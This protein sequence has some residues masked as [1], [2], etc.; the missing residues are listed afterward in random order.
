MS[1][2]KPARA[3]GETVPVPGR[4]RRSARKMKLFGPC[5][6]HGRVQG[7]CFKQRHTRPVPR[8]GRT[9]SAPPP[10]CRRFPAGE[11]SLKHAHPRQP[12]A[13]RHHPSRLP[14]PW[15][16]LSSLSR[17]SC[18]CLIACSCS[19]SRQ[20]PRPPRD[21]TCPALRPSRLFRRQLL[22]R[23]APAPSP[24]QAKPFP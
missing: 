19:A 2:P 17:A 3:R 9:P 10:G 12:S 5:S 8:T 15:R 14:L 4:I 16:P 20:K 11:S 23:P 1:R 7:G 6:S 22:L 24:R 21:S 18:P 13:P